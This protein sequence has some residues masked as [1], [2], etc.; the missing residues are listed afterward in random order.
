M[1]TLQKIQLGAIVTTLQV[2]HN[3]LG[4]LYE[5]LQREQ[6]ETLD[7]LSS[8][9]VALGQIVGILSEYLA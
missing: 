2:V 9:D 5:E 6:T 8:V 1:T 3:Q 4:A 7:R